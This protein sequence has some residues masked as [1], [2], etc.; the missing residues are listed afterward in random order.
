MWFFEEEEDETIALTN[1]ELDNILSSADITE[2]VVEENPI[3][4]E[5]EIPQQ[6]GQLIDKEDII[7]YGVDKEEK[8]SEAPEETPTEEI[9]LEL[10]EEETEQSEEIELELP[11]EQPGG[12]ED[13]ELPETELEL[14][15]T[16]AE[17]TEEAPEETSEEALLETSEEI[18]PE[19]SKKEDEHAG[20]AGMVTRLEAFVDLLNA[21]KEKKKNGNGRK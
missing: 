5:E 19:T 16:T 17:T 12:A 18:E 13:L 1:D 20:E 10:P 11:E 2:E 9:E 21:K 6:E 15:E 8:S 14:E 7:D 3:S 4:I